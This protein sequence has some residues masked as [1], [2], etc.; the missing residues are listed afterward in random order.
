MHKI[1]EILK[2]KFLIFSA[3]GVIGYF[4]LRG[5]LKN[6][7]DPDKD[8]P[9]LAKK[10]NFHKI[11]DNKNNFRS[12]QIPA[13]ALPGI[14]KKYGIKHIIRLNGDGA[15]GRDKPTDA[16]VTKAAE[17]K[18]AE[19][20]GAIFHVLNAHSGYT[21]NKGYTQSVT[22]AGLILDKGNTLIHCAHGSDRTGALVGG[23][24]KNKGYMTNLDKLWEYTTKYNGW[25][26][27]IKDK[28]FFGSGYDKYADSFYPLDLLKKSK[29]VK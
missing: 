9:E 16:I 2:S 10:F 12:G 19:Q 24:L 3:I 18:I 4:L 22:D 5:Q 11:P 15:D 7:L 8:D 21:K 29:W 23:Y 26:R 6:F 13:S 27:M 1:L 25:Q 28:R 20:N 14:I 17:K